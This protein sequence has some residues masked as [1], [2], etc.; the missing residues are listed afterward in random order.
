MEADRPDW[1]REGRDWPNRQASRFLSAGGIDW[2]VQQFGT[3]PAALLIHGTGASSHSFRAMSERL[4]GHL[5][6]T[7]PDLPDH[8]FSRAR[9]GFRHSLPKIADALHR[10]LLALSVDP[11]VVIGHSAGAAIGAAMC[12]GGTLT[13]RSLISLNGAFLPFD[14]LAGQIFPSIARL[15]F[16][17]PF[18][19][20]LFAWSVDQASVARLIRETGSKLDVRGIEFYERLLRRPGHVAGALGMMAN[21]D[22][23]PL[24]KALPRLDVPVLL[25]AGSKDR[26]I[27]PSMALRVVKMLPQGRVEIINGLG[28]L[29]HEERPLEIAD[30]IVGFAEETGGLG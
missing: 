23:E 24:A 12:L 17:N 28:H 27:P 13:P 6:L 22:L 20:H 30:R 7:I 29:A 10:L 1:A 3:G 9:P 19:P 4:A 14:G 11:V 21:W 16:L 26:S 15:L 8:G 25:M 18:A 5:S 2:H